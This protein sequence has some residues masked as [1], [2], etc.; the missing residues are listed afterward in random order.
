MK[1]IYVFI[2][3]FFSICFFGFSKPVLQYSD[4]TDDDYTYLYS[5]DCYTDV[6]TD[7]VSGIISSFDINENGMLVMIVSVKDEKSAFDYKDYLLLY[8][9]K[10]D[11]LNGYLLN[12]ENNIIYI[13]YIDKNIGI[14]YQRGS[15]LQV[16]DTEGNKIALK[17]IHNTHDF[18]KYLSSKN[19]KEVN[20]YKYYADKPT[21][22]FPINLFTN[23]TRMIIE[24]PEGNKKI[25]SDGYDKENQS[26]TIEALFIIFSTIIGM[27]GLILGLNDKYRTKK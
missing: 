9:S 4:Y 25:I 12:N 7:S 11:F 6:I 1:K 24:D 5:S 10:G 27:T 17:E 8:N 23:P 20:G 22:F 15:I 19:P 3:L 16:M 18:F 14:I 2:L 21:G 26:I 13:T